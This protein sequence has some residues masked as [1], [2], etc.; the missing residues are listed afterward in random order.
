MSNI[1][2]APG[3]FGFVG[4]CYQT[5]SITQDDQECINWFP[6]VDPAKSPGERGVVAL[7]PTPGYIAK[8]AFVTQ[9]PIR[10]MLPGP[11]GEFLYVIAG[12]GFYEIGANFLSTGLVLG[13]LLT[14]TGAASLTTNGNQ[15]YMC[16]GA[17]RYSWDINTRVFTIIAPADGSFTGADRVDVIDNF[18]IYNK[19]NS[20]TWAATDINSA[21]T[22]ALSFGRKDSAPDNIVTIIVNKREIF[23]LGIR[24]SEVWVDAGLFPFPF[25]KLPGTNMQ[26]GCA[27]PLSPA[28]LGESFAFLGADDR[29]NT[30]VFLMEGYV[31]RNI[32]TQALSAELDT[33][34]VVSD[35]IG[36]SYEQNGHEFYVL[37]FPSADKTWCYDLSTGL[38]HRRA[39]RDNANVLHRDHANCAANFQG[40]NLFGDKGNGLIYAASTST[41][42]DFS[43]IGNVIPRIRR[44][45]H[46][47]ADLNEV[48][49]HD[50]QIQF[51]PGVGLETGLG[52][53]P[54]AMLKW[55]DDG[56]FTWS[57]ERWVSIG[58]VGRYKNRARWQQLGKSRDRIFEVQVTDPVFPVIVSAN[59]RF[60]PG[61]S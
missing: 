34:G 55:S 39:V 53:D 28:F 6:E 33:Y 41:F 16:D 17:N 58:R 54:Q 49:Y 26:H 22:S 43:D 60:S 9:V 40:F 2:Q 23:I 10:A 61:A 36:M 5:Q 14:A 57:N 25:Q 56:G 3:D 31:P 51:Q 12:N 48:Y 47:T 21:T 4:A 7:Y 50:L 11:T 35:A 38:W 32:A 19:P 20:N 8:V 42:T 15:F 27:A 30:N 44:C 52:E 46:L 37:T 59:L 45:R 24:T 18:I 29:G 13:N 1:S